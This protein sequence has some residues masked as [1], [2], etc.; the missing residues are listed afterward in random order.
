MSNDVEK[1]DGLHRLEKIVATLRSPN[2][3]P[4]DREQ[5]L[6]SLRPCLIEEAYELLDAIDK[7][8]IALHREELG[9]VL[10]QVVLQAQLRR[11]E[12]HFTL[13]DVANAIADKLVR[14]HPHV[15]GDVKVNST[16]EVLSNWEAIKRNE[17]KEKTDAP[18]SPLAGVPAALP[19]LLRAQRVQSKCAKAGFDWNKVT[20]ARDKLKEELQELD[21]A[22]AEGDI[23]HIAE[24][25]G[26]TLFAMTSVARK[27]GIDAETALRDSTSKF[28]ARYEHVEASA[29][30]DGVELNTLSTDDLLTRWKAAKV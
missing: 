23:A 5:T 18:K 14:R 10:L 28:I 3:C 27:L 30:K 4:W 12:G 8:D 7:D 20:E 17:G 15:F 1:V 11:E 24:E 16:A 25:L 21:E 9:D 19:A 13:D 26:D 2:G 6:S 29:R 22:I